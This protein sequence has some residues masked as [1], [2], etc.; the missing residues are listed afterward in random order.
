MNTQLTS[1]N[2][3]GPALAGA[4][5]IAMTLA[6]CA[7][8]DDTAGDATTNGE[9]TAEGDQTVVV[10]HYFAEP[11]QVA[12]MDRYAEMF[13]DANPGATVQNV[14]V[15]YDQ[16]MSNLV[17]ATGE[18]EG[19]D[20][21]VYNGAETSTLALAGSLIPLDDYIAEWDDVDELPDSVLHRLDD[22]TYGVQGYVN[23]LGLWYNQDLLDEIGAE[24]PTTM[25]ELEATMQLGVDAGYEGITL[26]AL[27]QGQGEWQAY[28]WITSEGFT[29]D[30]PD[31][32][33]LE[34]GLA[35]I[36]GWIDSGYL[37]QEAVT[38]DQT[39]PFQEFA[40]GGILFAQ[41]GN[42][43]IGT[44]EADADFEYGVAPLPLSSTGG[45]YLGGEGQGIGANATNPDLAWEYLTTTYLSVEGQ[46]AA[47]ELV[48]SIPSRA[49]ASQD[50][51]VTDNELLTAFA[52]TLNEMG[53]NYPHPNIQ[54]E[55]V[56][57]VQLAMGQVWSAVLGNQQDAA[58]GAEQA[59]AGLAGLLV[60]E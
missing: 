58:A 36:R 5:A 29:Y 49:D 50:S 18:G 24:P 20:I 52:T 47:V 17:A 48:G 25:D 59:V 22:A 4:L 38:W 51:A 7:T 9:A 14:Y 31:A 16:L 45:V 1:R 21:A 56:P 3:R 42:W 34:S 11:N 53:A 35:R 39:V 12:L 15:P 23:L 8:A 57:D 44:A 54:P 32:A 2:R 6:A 46:L 41:N 28:P 19:P 30:A 26:S 33:A 40:A 60:S 10:W 55:A 13:E 37:S 27:P 43:Q